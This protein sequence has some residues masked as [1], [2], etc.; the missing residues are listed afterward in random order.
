MDDIKGQ[1]SASQGV[2]RFD[3]WGQ[4]GGDK[5]EDIFKVQSDDGTTAV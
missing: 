2:G 5:Q 1:N 3:R 4:V